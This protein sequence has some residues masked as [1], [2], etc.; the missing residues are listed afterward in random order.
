MRNFKEISLLTAS[1][2]FDRHIL[3]YHCNT[4]H[5][6]RTGKG[7]NTPRHTDSIK[8]RKGQLILYRV[9]SS[10]NALLANV[11]VAELFVGFHLPATGRVFVH[12]SRENVTSCFRWLNELEYLTMT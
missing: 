2:P 9:E 10:R 1:R 12:A 11:H 6:T 3:A 4:I 5:G 8:Q 7:R